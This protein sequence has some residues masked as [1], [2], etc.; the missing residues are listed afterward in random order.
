MPSRITNIN[1]AKNPKVDVVCVGMVTPAEVY[2]VEKMPDWNTGTNW[3]H[4][5]DFI[6]DDAAIVACCITNWGLS[7]GLVCNK[8]GDDLAGN[9]VFDELESMGVMGRFIKDKSLRTPYEIVISDSEGGR[10]YFWDRREDLL[11]TLE[12]AD[13]DTIKNAKCVYADWYDYPYNRPAIQEA[14]DQGLPVLINIE[15]QY[16]DS[17]LISELVGLATWFQCTP[18]QTSNAH[19]KYET[20]EELLRLGVEGVLFTGSEDGCIWK[21]D[22]ESFSVLAPSINLVDANG[23]GAVLSAGFLYGYTQGFDMEY[24]CRFAVSAASKQCELVS[25]MALP[26]EEI[27]RLARELKVRDF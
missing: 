3:N 24:S 8:L 20:C 16:A 18:D 2:V 11:R 22:R 10:T 14:V 5:A 12:E 4:R 13:T 1:R 27:E 23:A 6:S 15:D 9:N 17:N 7:G 25:P 21:S 19:K 26:V